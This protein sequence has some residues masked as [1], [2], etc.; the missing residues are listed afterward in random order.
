MKQLLTDKAQRVAIKEVKI[1]QGRIQDKKDNNAISM[2]DE[3]KHISLHY[4]FNSLHQSDF[5]YLHVR[6][7][8]IFPLPNT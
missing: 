3:L 1:N 6:Y 7:I 8:Y 4:T 2:D 5:I